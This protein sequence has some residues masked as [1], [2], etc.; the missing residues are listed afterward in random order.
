ML[1]DPVPELRRQLA[2]EI[3]ALASQMN[4]FVA[5]LELGID[6]PRLSDLAHGRVDRFSLNRLVRMLANVDRRV[7]LSVRHEPPPKRRHTRWRGATRE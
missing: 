2:R 7:E 1:D 5:A 6:P 3:V 4:F